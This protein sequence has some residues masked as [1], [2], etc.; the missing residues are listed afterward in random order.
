MHICCIYIMQSAKQ[1]AIEF[2]VKDLYKIST[3]SVP[4][5]ISYISSSLKKAGYTTEIIFCNPF[6]YKKGITDYIEQEP[7]IFTITITSV[8]DIPLATDLI[9][10][11]RLHYKTSKIIVGG[12]Y[13]TISPEQILRDIKEI[14]AICIGAGEKSI[15]E[16][17]KQVKEGKYHKTDNLWIKNGDEVIKCDKSLSVENLDDLPYPDRDGWERWLYHSDKHKTNWE[18]WLSDSDNFKVVLMSRGCI[19][20]CIFCSNKEL[21]KISHNRYFNVRSIKSIVEEIDFI[22]KKYKNVKGIVLEGENALADLD[23]F[24]SLCI[25]LKEYNNKLENKLE[26]S[27]NINFTSNL[28]N[29]DMD[30]ISLM[31]E[32][33][34]T[35]I[36]FS[37]ESGSLEIRKI[38]NKPLYDNEQ[39]ITFCDKMHKVGIAIMIYTMY[40]FP[41]ETKETYWQT[42][43]CLRACKPE[44]FKYTW[45]QLYD[46]AVNKKVTFAD[47]YRFFTLKFR[48]YIKYTNIFRTIA[49]TLSVDKMFDR[50]S[51][52][53]KFKFVRITEDKYEELA[54]QELDKGNFKQAIKYFDK[55]KIKEDNYWIYGDRAIA[56]MNIGD[57]EGAIKDF[58]KVI[59]LDP[60]E[61]YK[62][63]KQECLNLLNS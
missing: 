5:G 20:N 49:L 11:L 55:T 41:F 54:K 40:C 22:V 2:S 60:K 13:V 32:A 6:T 26:F 46:R 44:H 10:T 29:K 15:V 23:R 12:A 45:L 19:Y 47:L 39:F 28:L 56:K 37:L 9:K 51:E 53:K 35:F 24:K 17:V 38:L 25:A 50:I 52:V 57:Y 62:Q 4:L 21:R 31:K 27:V 34:F 1:I 16:Y 18:K 8:V 30:V 61:I 63:K 48:V 3:L 33:N 59:E 58:D 36:R 14:D 43:D 42:V 7:Q